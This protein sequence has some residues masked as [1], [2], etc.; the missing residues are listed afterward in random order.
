MKKT[1]KQII[2]EGDAPVQ[3]IGGTAYK[4]SNPLYKCTDPDYG[5]WNKVVNGVPFIRLSVK[6]TRAEKRAEKSARRIQK[7]LDKSLAEA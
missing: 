7:R 5:V 3:Y 2:I 4:G 6:K 1:I